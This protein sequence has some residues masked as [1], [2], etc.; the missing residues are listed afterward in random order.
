MIP[1]IA[2]E[3]IESTRLKMRKIIASD[4][5]AMFRIFSEHEIVKWAGCKILNNISESIPHINSYE[6]RYL[7]GSQIAWAVEF[8]ENN[9]MIGFIALSYIDRFHAF[10]YLGSS[11]LTEYSNLGI[12]TEANKAVINFAFTKT[13]LNRI[14]SQVYEK[15]YAMLRVNEKSGFSKE[16]LIRENF[17]IDGKYCNS[18]MFSIIKSDFLM[19]QDFFNFNKK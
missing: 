8:K 12:T 2:F 16:A 3:S 15:H 14:E 19:N 7:A 18:I 10:A 17:N 11:L 5:K 9:E 13:G 4:E 6:E 1:V